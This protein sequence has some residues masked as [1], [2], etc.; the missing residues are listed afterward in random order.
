MVFWRNGFSTFCTSPHNI[1]YSRNTLPGQAN[2]NVITGRYIP[3]LPTSDRTDIYPL[4]PFIIELDLSQRCHNSDFATLAHSKMNGIYLGNLRN[5]RIFP[6]CQPVT[7]SGLPVSGIWF[8]TNTYHHTI[9][10]EGQFCF[11]PLT[12]YLFNFPGTIYFTGILLRQNKSCSS[13]YL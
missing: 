4:D 5:G 10:H 1:I 7:L 8:F 12:A 13:Q 3:L 9:C 6:C 2:K 11:P